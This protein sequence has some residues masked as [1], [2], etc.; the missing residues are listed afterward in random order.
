MCTRL[1]KCVKTEFLYW[2]SCFEIPAHVLSKS[3]ESIRG[4][5]CIE[6]G[7]SVNRHDF[8]L[9]SPELT[10]SVVAVRDLQLAAFFTSKEQSAHLL[11]EFQLVHT[12]DALLC[13]RFLLSANVSP[14]I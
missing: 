3:F 10:C 1:Q 11:K 6:S 9:S 4:P 2:G 12:L 13:L 8:G 14:S 5:L 7:M